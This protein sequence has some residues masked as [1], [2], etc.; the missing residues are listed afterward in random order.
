MSDR[1]VEVEATTLQASVVELF[2]GKKE[3]RM[4]DLSDALEV[5]EDTVVHA[6]LAFW[7]GE[8]VLREQGDLWVL[9]D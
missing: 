2:E 3:W 5:K 8:G 1:I 7:V 6:A 4:A 9:L